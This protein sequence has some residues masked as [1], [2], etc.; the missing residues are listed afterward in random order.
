MQT[1]G[2]DTVFVIDVNRV[3]AALAAHGKNLLMEFDAS[4]GEETNVSAAGRFR[5]WEVVEGGAAKI[6]YI[7]M[8]ILEGELTVGENLFS[9]VLRELPDTSK[10]IGA[11][12][13][14][15][16]LAGGARAVDLAGVSVVMAVSLHLLPRFDGPAPA[17]DSQDLKFDIQGVGSGTPVP[18]LVTPVNVIDPSGR[19]TQ[20]DKGLL[21]A[22]L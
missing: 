11:E 20:A 4:L 17:S 16:A 21:L 6:L 7:Q 8:P 3:N 1:F 18:G 22:T 13:L 10:V 15:E 12:L 19:L 5:A 14:G 2:W 9:S